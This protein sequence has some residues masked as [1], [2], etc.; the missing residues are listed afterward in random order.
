[1]VDVAKGVLMSL[2]Q[3]TFKSKGWKAFHMQ[4]STV[5]NKVLGLDGLYCLNQI[6]PQ[7]TGTCSD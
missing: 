2:G 1:M 7:F 3:R 4:L 5:E 6:L